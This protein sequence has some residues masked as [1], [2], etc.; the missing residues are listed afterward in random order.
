MF[1]AYIFKISAWGYV[2][3]HST[4]SLGSKYEESIS[5]G[6]SHVTLSFYIFLIFETLLYFQKSF[7]F[8][9]F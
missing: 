4:L 9:K 7:F 8:L 5:R 6:Y 1:I 2:L 3:F